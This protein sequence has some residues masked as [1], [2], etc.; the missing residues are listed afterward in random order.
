M[1]LQCAEVMGLR[2]FIIP[3]PFLSIGLSSYWLNLFTPVPYG[4]AASLIEGLRS[5]V[6]V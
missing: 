2:R 1:M 5:E 3:V 4:V 6:V